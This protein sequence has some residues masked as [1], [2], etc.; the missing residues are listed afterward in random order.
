MVL[1]TLA[2]FVV[3]AI[4]VVGIVNRQFHEVVGQEQEEQAFQ[5]AEAGID[6]VV[7]L[8]DQH[9]VDLENPQPIT[10]YEVVDFTKDPSE[11]LG[12]FTVTIETVRYT[13]PN[14][15]AV[16]RLVSVGRDAVL[17]NRTQTI[18][19]VIQSEADPSE[20]IPP[21]NEPDQ[22]EVW[23]IIEWDHKP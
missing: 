14:G 19:A 21:G 8:L 9:L 6:Y 11:V 18:E 17:I 13:P 20:P 12:K 23:R 15:P 5:I 10:D 3:M 4:A 7:W 1:V 22:L 2:V 16:M